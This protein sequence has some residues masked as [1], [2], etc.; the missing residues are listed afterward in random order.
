MNTRHTDIKA[1]K[2]KLGHRTMQ[3][4]K[5]LLW[6]PEAGQADHCGEGPDGST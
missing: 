5:R 1:H 3:Q 4:S 2:R 6:N